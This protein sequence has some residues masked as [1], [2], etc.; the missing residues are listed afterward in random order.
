MSVFNSCITINSQ[1]MHTGSGSYFLR[2]AISVTFASYVNS[3]HSSFLEW[4]L[5]LTET[6]E[7]WTDSMVNLYMQIKNIGDVTNSTRLGT[8]FRQGLFTSCLCFGRQFHALFCVKSI[9]D[10]D[11]GSLNRLYDEIVYAKFKIVVTQVKLS[12]TTVTS[13]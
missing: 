13:G 7:P 1:K 10:L 6:L 4:I 11:F 3:M 9:S 2:R 12:K 5:F 8:Y